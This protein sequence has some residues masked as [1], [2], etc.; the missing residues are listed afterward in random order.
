MKNIL[1][2]DV[3]YQLPS[4]EHE[5]NTGARYNPPLISDPPEHS[6]HCFRTQK[7][8]F[9]LPRRI[10]A[11]LLC[12]LLSAALLITGC[13]KKDKKKTASEKDSVRPAASSSDSG[14]QSGKS[15]N[16]KTEESG[17]T[18]PDRSSDT[19]VEAVFFDVGKGDC[20]LFT[21]GDSHVMVDAGYKETSEDILKELKK[22]DVES[23]DALIITHYDKD[24]VG[25]AAGIASAIP[26]NMIYLPDYDGKPDKCGDLMKLID[27]ENLPHTRVASTEEFDADGAD[28][29]VHPALI[30]Y[31]PVITNDNDASL[32]VEVFCGNDQWL[33]PGD[34]EEEAIDAWL[35]TNQQEYDVL[36]YPHHGKKESNASDFV[37]NVSPK[38]TVITDSTDKHAAKK[39]LKMLDES[40]VDVYRS[41]EN[42][43]ITITGNG[44]EDFYVSTEK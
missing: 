4:E 25:G 8:P 20:I 12:C 11:V 23:L 32:I 41:S 7:R 2:N 37:S 17:Q 10:C 18:S 24:H 30:A 26:V 6:G 42:G 29:K 39:V 21:C 31:D 14:G 9:C 15:G 28:F 34:I 43:T 35:E 3:K 13:S 40:E 1:Q 27:S 38:I 5:S 33:L 22:R 16:S 19:T 36:K 44:N